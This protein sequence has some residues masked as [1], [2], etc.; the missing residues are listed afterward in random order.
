MGEKQL[1]LRRDDRCRRC[2]ASV[3][4]GSSAWWD[5]DAKVVTC[6]GCHL[7]SAVPV[8]V[9]APAAQPP[10]PGEGGRSAQRE[11]E[12]RS[13]RELARKQAVVEEDAARRARIKAKRP[14]IGRLASAM[15]PKPVIPPESQS[16]KAWAVGAVGERRVE[17]VLASCDGVV[18]LH[19]RLMP[20]SRANID[21]IAV[22][23]SGVYVIDA[24]R[25]EGDVEARDVGGWLHADVR[26]YV[27]G[28]DRT[29]LVD[30]MSRQVEAVRSALGGSPI[31]IHPVLCFVDG[32]WPRLRR[33]PLCVRGVT[34][35]W[36]DG[37]AKVLT[38]TS[39]SPVQDPGLVAAQ[40]AA[41]LR[42][43]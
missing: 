17:E 40:I 41:R 22:A 32:M 39:E 26:L 42:V 10:D 34:V 15:T 3:E 13:G 24:K 38:A 25:Y 23:P 31:P 28:R 2:D 30:E 36:P 14:V 12:R 5:P 18:V 7:S 35:V 21:H 27:K 37:L 20:R 9:V 43:A 6:S 11:Y 4:A 29:K 19:D 33:R 16:T 8:Q 1:K